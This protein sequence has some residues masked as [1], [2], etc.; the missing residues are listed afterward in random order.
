MGISMGHSG[1]QVA[2]Y[3]TYKALQ[4]VRALH[5]LQ[6]VKMVYFAHGWHLAYFGKPLLKHKVK[7]YAYGPVISDVYKRYKSEGISKSDSAFN[8]L[9]LWWWE[10]FKPFSDDTKKLL[11]KVYDSYVKFSGVQ[12]STMAQGENSPWYLDGTMQNCIVDGECIRNFNL[13]NE[14]IE[15]FFKKQLEIYK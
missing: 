10:R 12:L 6:I 2:K 1:L 8:P 15:C 7:G 3:F 14:T 13:R 9:E 5:A 4:E 11:D